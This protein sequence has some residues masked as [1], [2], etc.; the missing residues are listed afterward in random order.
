MVKDKLIP[1]ILKQITPILEKII[2]RISVDF[3]LDEKQLKKVYLQDL[4]NY[5]KR[6]SKRKGIINPYA[7][8]LGDKKIEKKLRND[9]PEASFGE[10][11]KLK[12]P[13][14]KSLSE[15][16]KQKYSDIA[17]EYDVEGYPTVKLLT[18]SGEV[19]E[20]NNER[21]ADGI[22]EFLRSLD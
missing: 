19:K 17:K 13:L 12:G 5:K 6:Q 7:A 18:D 14:W 9:N 3:N 8:F 15:S 16:D 21:T 10:L 20:Y 11:S 4:R 2:E 1:I 22:E